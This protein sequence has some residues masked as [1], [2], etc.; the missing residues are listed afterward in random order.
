MKLKLCC[1]A[2]QSK[3]LEKGNRCGKRKRQGGGEWRDGE[4]WRD[5]EK[6]AGW[7]EVSGEQGS[8]GGQI[9]EHFTL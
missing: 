4:G 1:I 6:G 3:A 5:G 7:R 9:R 2:L 8:E